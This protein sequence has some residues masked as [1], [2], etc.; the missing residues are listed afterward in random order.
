M[1]KVKAFKIIGWFMFIVGVLSLPI[2]YDLDMIEHTPLAF[3]YMVM[4]LVS[5]AVW[6]SIG[7]VLIL[8][9]G[10]K[11]KLDELK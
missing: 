5:S 11:K 2:P 7:L 6:I 3:E 9:M 8:K 10:K 4:S 1:N